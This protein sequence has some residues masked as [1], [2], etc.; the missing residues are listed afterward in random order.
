MLVRR[1]I[2]TPSVANG[3]ERGSVGGE[4][5]P[6]SFPSGPPYRGKCCAFAAVR[7]QSRGRCRSESGI[8]ASVL[9]HG[10]AVMGC[11]LRDLRAALLRR[12]LRARATGVA[13][14]VGDLLELR[15]EAVDVELLDRRELLARRVDRS[16]DVRLVGV[17]EAVRL[18]SRRG[19]DAVLVEAQ[20][21]L[22]RAR[23]REQV[24]DRLAA[25]RVGDR[26]RA[27]LERRE[28][29]A[30]AR[31]DLGER[32]SRRRGPRRA[33]RGAARAGPRASRRRA[34]RRAGTRR[35]STSG[36]R[37]ASAGARAARRAPRARPPR[38]GPRRARGVDLDVE[39]VARRAVEGRPAVGADL[40][41][42]A[43]GRAAA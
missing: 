35:G 27:A 31:G 34:A 32:G 3:P 37:R 12:A 5:L 24:G 33:A 10:H 43:E 40:R 23:D 26:V 17:R 1:R 42:D 14:Q 28:R 39:L 16:L 8:S 15:R 11:R 41:A 18:G 29:D 20:R 6:R 38:G 7:S 25:L 9:Q 36:R 4:G 30:L 13:A 22:A 21:R 2:Q 19:D